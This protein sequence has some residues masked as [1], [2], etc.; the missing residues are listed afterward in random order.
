MAHGENAQ[1]NGSRGKEYWKSRLHRWGEK[2]GRDTKTLTHR[3]ERQIGKRITTE[4][5]SE[6]EEDALF[7]EIGPETWPI[8]DQ[9]Y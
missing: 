2:P 6:A 8:E 5:V 4:M 3:H 9:V 7:S 1:K